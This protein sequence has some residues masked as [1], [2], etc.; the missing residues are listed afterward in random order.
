MNI[1]QQIIALNKFLSRIYESDD[2]RISDLLSA[3]GLKRQPG[4]VKS[5]LEKIGLK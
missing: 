2:M 5:R 1:K 4:A 3:I